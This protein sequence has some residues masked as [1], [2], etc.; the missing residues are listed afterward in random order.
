MQENHDPLAEILKQA[1]LDPGSRPVFY[2]ALLKADVY[3]IGR[4][5]KKEDNDNGATVELKHYH[6]KKGEKFIPFFTSK[7]ALESVAKDVPILKIPAR[8]FFETTLGERLFLNVGCEQGKEFLE[9]EVKRLLD[10]SLFA[11]SESKVFEKDTKVLISQPREYPHA[12]VNSLSSYFTEH[13]EVQSA[14][15]CQIFIAD[16]QKRPPHPFIGVAFDT[17]D[18]AIIKKIINE[19]MI[20]AGE[21]NTGHVGFINL[22]DNAKR[23][24]YFKSIKP[25]YQKRWSSKLKAGV[26][27]FLH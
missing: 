6:N 3:L 17:K 5:V 13:S 21:V 24:R 11:Q 12:L 18:A 27:K 7:A 2:E 22:E 19:A 15:L 23:D 16:E 9:H 25:F 20:V 1:A 10:G 4:V 8:Q 26:S 14:Y